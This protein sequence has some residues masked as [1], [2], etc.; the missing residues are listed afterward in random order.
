M[1]VVA[2]VK[3]KGNWFWWDSG[4]KVYSRKEGVTY[5]C[6][7]TPTVRY[8]KVLANHPLSTW[9]HQSLIQCQQACGTA[10]TYFNILVIPRLARNLPVLSSRST[11]LMPSE[12]KSYLYFSFI[13][14]RLEHKIT[15]SKIAVVLQYENNYKPS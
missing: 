8:T 11:D 9:M 13:I 6:N 12:G 10:N 3:L 15:A 14:P 7:N 1:S 4:D 2:G 5:G